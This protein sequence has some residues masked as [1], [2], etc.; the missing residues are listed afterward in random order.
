MVK[1]GGK[2]YHHLTHGDA[3]GNL[4]S[5]DKL[6]KTFFDNGGESRISIA[7]EVSVHKPKQNES[8]A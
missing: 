4:Q 2:N 1:N 6:A 3:T 5:G 7:I 8:K